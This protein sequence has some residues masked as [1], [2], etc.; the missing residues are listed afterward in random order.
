MDIRLFKKT[1]I[2]CYSQASLVYQG[3]TNLPCKWLLNIPSAFIAK[4][5]RFALFHTFV[6]DYSK[7]PGSSPFS[8]APS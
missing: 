7:I 3:Q 8:I 2:I 1:G 6:K 5:C 4:S